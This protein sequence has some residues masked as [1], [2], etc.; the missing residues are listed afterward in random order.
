[1]FTNFLMWIFGIRRIRG[2]KKAPKRKTNIM[3]LNRED[4]N[5]E[6]LIQI[7]TIG[8]MYSGQAKECMDIEYFILEHCWE[9]AY[10]PNSTA[11]RIL[12]SMKKFYY[13]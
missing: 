12:L 6:V 11:K 2:S 3:Y 4:W 5:R 13:P 7:E 10:T 8:E 9:M 1:M